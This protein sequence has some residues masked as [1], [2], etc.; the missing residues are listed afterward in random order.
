MHWIADFLFFQQML[1]G[2]GEVQRLGYN[3]G[4]SWGGV[5]A[6]REHPE[7]D[8]RTQAHAVVMD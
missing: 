1:Q 7:R 3:S 4:V 8:A 5:R 2:W 6:V